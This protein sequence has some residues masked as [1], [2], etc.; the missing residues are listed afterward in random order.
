M[1]SRLDCI[2]SSPQLEKRQ[3]SRLS[4]ASSLISPIRSPLQ[5]RKN[6]YKTIKQQATMLEQRKKLLDSYRRRNTQMHEICEKL[7]LELQIP[8]P[9]KAS[10]S[11]DSVSENP[12]QKDEEEIIPDFVPV[13]QAFGNF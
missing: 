8:N 6:L 9:S 7:S 1:S 5:D 10:A 12:Q 13:E 3:I 4:S 11:V 2:F